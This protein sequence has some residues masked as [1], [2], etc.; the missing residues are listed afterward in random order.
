MSTIKQIKYQNLGWESAG[1]LYLPSDFD[2]SKTYPAIVSTHP[3]GS[4]KE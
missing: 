3:I 4:C 1:H 2:E